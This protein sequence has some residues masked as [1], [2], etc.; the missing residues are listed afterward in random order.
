MDEVEFHAPPRESKSKRWL[1]FHPFSGKPCPIRVCYWAQAHNYLRFHAPQVIGYWDGLPFGY[2][3]QEAFE[4][5]V[6]PEFP[7]WQAAQ[8]FPEGQHNDTWEKG[9]DEQLDRKGRITFWCFPPWIQFWR[10]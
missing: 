9:G 3:D 2:T 5:E 6:A 4:A 8:V 10:H 1:S 7:P